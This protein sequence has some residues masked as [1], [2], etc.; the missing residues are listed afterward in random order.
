MID[1]STVAVDVLDTLE[2]AVAEEVFALGRADAWPHS[3]A[4]LAGTTVSR[5]GGDIVVRVKGDVPNFIEHGLGPGG[6]G[7]EGPFDMRQ[8]IL[9][10]RDM[11]AVPI[12]PGIVR[13][14]SARGKPWIHPGFKAIRVLARVN[15]NIVKILAVAD[16]QKYPMRKLNSGR[17]W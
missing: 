16:E 2:A 1:F 6:L 15:D 13:M 4:Y 10:G 8:N 3:A 14:M 11:R 7:T 5:E 17:W 12:A 9:K